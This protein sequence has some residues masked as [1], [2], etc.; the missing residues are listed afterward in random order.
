MNAWAS[1]W[2]TII[3]FHRDKFLPWIAFRNA[4]GVAAPLIAGAITGQLGPAVTVATG[5]LNVAFSDGYEPYIVRARRMLAASVLVALGVSI[6]ALVGGNTW[7]AVAVAG[8]WAFAAGMMVA[9]STAA[10]D[11]GG[12]SLV[13]MLVFAAVYRDPAHAAQAGLLAFCGGLLQ[14]GL[15]L[16]LWRL[17]PYNAERRALADLYVELSKMAHAVHIDAA[18]SPPASAPFTHAQQTLASLDRDRSVDGE[19][20]RMLLSEAERIRL[21]MLALRRVRA[22]IRREAADSEA[23]GVLGSYFETLSA[24]L[25]Q[26]G[27]GL[28]APAAGVSAPVELARF[29]PLSRRLREACASADAN[30]AAMIGDARSQMDAIAGQLRAAVD[31][32]AH[33][34]PAGQAAYARREHGKPWGLRLAGTLATLRANLHLQ[35]A[36]FRH[37]VRLAG[38]VAIGDA[39]GRGFGVDRSYWLPM[40]VAIVLKPDFAATFSRGVLRLAGTF[41]GLGV[42]TAMVHVLPPAPMAHAIAVGAL[43]YVMRCFGPANYGLFVTVL[44]AMVVALFTLAG[45]PAQQVIGARALNTALGGAIALGAY[46]LWPTWERTQAAESMARLLDAYREY[47]RAIAEAYIRGEAQRGAELDRKRWAARLART[48]MEASVERMS[49]EPRTAH[50]SPRMMS[51]MLASSHRMVQAMMSL[52]AG[53]SLS[54][55]APAREAFRRFAH[56][57]ELALY[58]L[59]AALRGSPMEAQHMPDLR[60]DHHALIASGDSLTERYALVNVETDRITNSLNTLAEATFY[61]LAADS[62]SAVVV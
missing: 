55:P 51:A 46:W 24:A 23:A 11:L 37:A 59:A 6:G 21:S 32:A 54:R 22:R 57:V 33:A 12:T 4:I 58:Y 34:D 9:L 5:A 49:A 8:A 3:T 27:R 56:D 52:E 31:L 44:T 35:S 13:T 7:L 17:R 50:E 43:M 45:V 30:T 53:L 2:R 1:L 62:A 41:L 48:N 10:G 39:V 60:E 16:A 26:I 38:C 40:T 29:E 18:E 28:A 42:A 36:A 20:Y 14:T 47:F 15:S 19:R 25:E 61:W